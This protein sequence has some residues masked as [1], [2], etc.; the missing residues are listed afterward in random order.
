MS[1]SKNP[2]TSLRMTNEN[3]NDIVFENRNK[4]YGAYTIR[5]DYDTNVAKAFFIT[6]GAFL[7]VVFIILLFYKPITIKKNKKPDTNTVECFFPFI[8]PDDNPKQDKQK[9]EQKKEKEIIKKSDD[10]KAN[11]EVKNDAKEKEKDLNDNKSNLGDEKKGDA[12]N[13]GDGKEKGKEGQEGF[14]KKIEEEKPKDPMLI[15]DT[16]PEFPGGIKKL[17][18]YLGKNIKYPEKANEIGIQGTVFLTFVVSETGEI[19]NVSLAKDSEGHS[20]TIGAGCE[21]AAMDVVKA[22][23]KWKPG[24]NKGVPVKVLYNLPVKFKLRN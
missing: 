12:S 3:L 4:N 2:S 17:M 1:H 9:N 11:V 20:K 16:M 5:R 15:P 23:P 21:D 14:G 24:K 13:A 22:M 6:A 19:S 8:S 10:L 7:S 18:E